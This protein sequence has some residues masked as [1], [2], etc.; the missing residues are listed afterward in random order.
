MHKIFKKLSG[1]YFYLVGGYKMITNWYSF[2]GDLLR[3]Q[4]GLKTKS[5]VYKLRDGTKINIHT[6]SKGLNYVFYSVYIKGEYDRFKKFEIN[7]N[8]IVIDIGAHLGFFSIK[9]AKKAP[10]GRVYAIEPFSM[11]YKL[12]Q[13]NIE[14]NLI[15]NVRLYNEAITDRVGELTFYYTNEGDPGDT[16]LYVINAKEKTYEEKIN[17]ISLN[18]F[19]MRE[20][21]DICNFLKL[22][23]EGAEYSIL[24][25]A[26]DSVL[27]KIQKIAMEWHRFDPQHDPLKLAAFLKKNGFKLIEP[28][29]YD[30]LTGLLYAYRE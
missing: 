15:K 5:S 2:W 30:S 4:L 18:N 26:G 11:H 12:L 24:L 6:N 21:I 19:F 29:S 27:N 16:S 7:R 20:K 3:I 8:D 9:A 17:S 1:L 25:N 22:D 23:C 28:S 13:K 14:E 10:Y